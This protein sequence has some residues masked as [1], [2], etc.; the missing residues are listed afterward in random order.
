MKKTLSY[1]KCSECGVF[2]TDKEYCEN[3]GA[4]IS[5]KKKQE[6]KAE[7][8]RKETLADAVEEIEQT[9]FVKRLK[10]HPNFLLRII[11]WCL[12]SVWFVI[13][14]IGMFLAWCIAMLAAG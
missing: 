12:Y 11:G 5:Y 3:C 4:L 9:N 2:N 13:T 6:L 14:A 1:I 7:K 8:V 10:E